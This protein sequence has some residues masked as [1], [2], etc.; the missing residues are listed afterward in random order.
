[1]AIF[2]QQNDNHYG[3]HNLKRNRL[4]A[5]KKHSSLWFVLS[6]LLSF[7]LM[8]VDC[9]DRSLPWVRTVFTGVMMPVQFAV[10]YPLRVVAWG[11]SLMSSKKTLVDENMRLR[12]QQ[13]VLEAQL[14][15]FLAL[16][17]ENS[18]L[19]SLLSASS[20]AQM[21]SMAARILAVDT[22]SSRQII[23]IS[24]GSRD[25]VVRG[26]AVLDARGVMGQVIDVGPLTSTVLLISDS[27]CAVPVLN[28]RT[29]ERAIVV[30]TTYIGRLSLVNLPKT[31]SVVVGDL[32]V[33]SGLG[34][35]YPEGYP[36]G[37]VEEVQNTSGEDFI[38]VL[39]SP[40]AWLN[41][42]RL[43]LLVWPEE[44]QNE[45]SMELVER[46]RVLEGVS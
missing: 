1:M 19:K 41:R 45:L 2:F 22:T 42:S 20:S 32:L 15:K 46:L 12:Y 29:G 43:V 23:V 8:M 21:R 27:K 24:K 13:T 16:R 17:N 18:E 34:E 40:V 14:Q 28:Q 39:V 38:K 26:Q 30:G 11:H 36:V 35:H 31:S 33:T 10:D 37:F 4:F 5:K 7:M 44:K 6:V 3:N 25:G 9:R